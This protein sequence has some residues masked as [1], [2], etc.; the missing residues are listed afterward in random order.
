MRHICP[1]AMEGLVWGG[2]SR[3]LLFRWGHREAMLPS[4]RTHGYD[5]S[6]NPFKARGSANGQCHP[7]VQRFLATRLLELCARQGVFDPPRN[8]VQVGQRAV[9]YR[10]SK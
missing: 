4:V 10:W 5:T 7:P 9:G 6:T 8:P 3:Y 1:F 2:P